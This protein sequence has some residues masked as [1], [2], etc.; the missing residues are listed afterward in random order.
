MSYDS[1]SNDENPIPSLAQLM[2][3]EDDFFDI[4]EEETALL[5]KESSSLPV[6]ANKSQKEEAI[7]KRASKES[8]IK[9]KPLK[10]DFIGKQNQE[11]LRQN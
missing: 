6:I 4:E 1:E 3:E 11:I 7:D 8:D 10:E 2:A 9:C 5:H